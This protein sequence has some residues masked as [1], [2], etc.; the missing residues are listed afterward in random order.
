MCVFLFCFYS[1][2]QLG[3]LNEKTDV[4]KKREIIQMK[5][6][7]EIKDGKGGQ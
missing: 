4:I 7:K 6:V 3:F 5:A 1:Y 2:S